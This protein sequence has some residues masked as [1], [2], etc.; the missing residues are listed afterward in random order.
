MSGPTDRNC[1]SVRI[2]PYDSVGQ[3]DRV[4]LDDGINQ[5]FFAASSVQSFRDDEH[6]SAFHWLWLGRYLADEPGHAFVALCSSGVCGYLVGS[7]SDPAQRA[8]FEELAY[9]SEFAPFTAQYPAHLHVNVD[10][11]WRSAGIGARL[12]TCFA[13]HAASAGVSGMHIVTGAGMRNVQFYERLGFE[14]VA[15]APRNGS[16]V[17]MLARSTR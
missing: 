8:E 1:G 5:I 3:M 17:V 12:V 7:L 11:N 15:R 10:Q 2:E 14:E 16:N 13:S 6:R 9:F 4:T